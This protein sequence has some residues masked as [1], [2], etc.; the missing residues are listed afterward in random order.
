MLASNVRL[1]RGLIPQI[2]ILCALGLLLQTCKTPG[3]GIV[4]KQR[5]SGYTLPTDPIL[6]F[7]TEN[8]TDAI[9]D[10][11]TDEEGKYLLTVSSD[12]TAKFWDANTGELINTIRVPLENSEDARRSEGDLWAAALSPDGKIAAF[13]GFTTDPKT[14]DNLIYLYNTETGQL[15]Q[16]LTG[17][18]RSVRDLEFSPDGRYLASSVQYE[19]LVIYRKSGSSE[20]Q[21]FKTFS[22]YDDALWDIAFDPSGRLAVGTFKELRLYDSRFNSVI[23][24]AKVG[25]GSSSLDF[26][27]DGNKLAVAFKNNMDAGET[28]VEVRSGQDLSLLYKPSLE[29]MSLGTD[30]KDMT[31]IAFSSD[32]QFLYAGGLNW[33]KNDE[34]NMI[35]AFRRW[36]Q[37]GRG[38]YQD[39]GVSYYYTAYIRG[40]QGVPGGNGVFFTIADGS[41]G[42]FDSSGK[43][44]IYHGPEFHSFGIIKQY[45]YL[46]VNRSGEQV[47][48]HA[49]TESHP[50][51][52]NMT[53][54]KLS[55][56]ENQ[57]GMEGYSTNKGGTKVRN[58]RG[59]I[60][61]V[62]SDKMEIN[63]DHVPNELFHVSGRVESIDVSNDGQRIILGMNTGQIVSTDA[64]GNIVWQKNTPGAVSAVN[65]SADNQVAVVALNNGFIR[66]YDVTHGGLIMTLYVQ[67]GTQE[68]VLFTPDGYFD[69]SP[70]G[71]ELLGWHINQGGDQAPEFYP[72]SRFY[73]QYYVPGLGRQILNGEEITTGR[74]NITENIDLPPEVEIVTPRDQMESEEKEL[75]VQIKVTDQGGGV[76]E[77]R[78]YHNGKLVQTT[79]RGLKLSGSNTEEFQVQLISGENRLRAVALNDQ[80]TESNPDEVNVNYK[81]ADTSFELYLFVIGINEYKNST[82]NLNYAHSD[83]SSFKEMIEKNASA[84]YSNINT[85]FIHD[86]QATKPNILRQLQKVSEEAEPQDVFM[87]YYAGHG[88][89]NEGTMGYEKD[90]YLVPYDVTQLYGADEQ[91]AEK[92]I[93]SQTLNEIAREIPARK[94]LF[95]L[96]ACQSGAAVDK[97]ALARGAAEEKAIAQLARSTGTYWMAA[98]GSEQF[99]TE[100]EELG[101]GVF[102]Y[103]VLQGLEGRA[104]AGTEDKKITAKELGAFIEDIVPQLSEEYKGQTQ[105]PRSYGFGQDFPIGVIK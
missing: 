73:E 45:E 7:N 81:G 78:L 85:F 30:K 53:T 91:L 20:F 96:D 76:D 46:K 65:I 24:S 48:F 56:Y 36:D 92:A 32:G 83:A 49:P 54:G 93:S 1:K 70:G 29:G 14:G 6:Q 68:W 40:I 41:W 61:Q 33:Q 89:M 2:V 102:T 4:E 72:L 11:S 67:R 34:G 17:L 51:Y 8:H 35:N 103:S 104:D 16:R 58:W 9:S 37:G 100:F 64:E 98:S 105:Y 66:W 5:I 15:V 71:E 26:S 62:G 84:I 79:S 42:K 101:H 75:T 31:E 43:F 57:Q 47:S 88:V 44:S 52:F 99:A 97:L 69:A 59:I 55:K 80:R 25:R 94:Q 63:G 77:V 19:Q 3:T 60:K 18:M 87:F 50:S 12:K 28:V 22:D 10:M 27:P 86:D 74:R 39:V 23:A 21:H 90:F 82:Y 38:T 13:S 95:L